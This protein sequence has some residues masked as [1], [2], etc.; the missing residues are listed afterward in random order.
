M[1]D[2]PSQKMPHGG[3]MC[4]ASKRNYVNYYHYSGVKNGFMINSFIYVEHH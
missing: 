4:G 2:L 3:H 1:D